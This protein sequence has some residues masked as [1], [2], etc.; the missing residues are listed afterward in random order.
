MGNP[1]LDG[2]TRIELFTNSS[3][4]IDVHLFWKLVK[5]VDFAA[6]KVIDLDS[7]LRARIIW[8]RFSNLGIQEVVQGS[9]LRLSKCEQYVQSRC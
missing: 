5:F 1:D 4:E 7:A 9:M 8:V 6:M 3:W 2:V